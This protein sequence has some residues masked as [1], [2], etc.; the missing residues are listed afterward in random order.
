LY[1]ETHN[2]HDILYREGKNRAVH[3]LPTAFIELCKESERSCHGLRSLSS[4]YELYRRTVSVQFKKHRTSLTNMR[5][6]TI[7]ISAFLTVI[8]LDSNSQDKIDNRVIGIFSQQMFYRFTI[9]EFK[10]DMTF[11]YH[12]MSRRAHRHTSGE[13][14][15]CGDTIILN[16][17][18]KNTDFDFQ[19]KKWII[20]SR[21]QIVTNENL[22][23][24]KE[25]W[26]IFERDKRF[27]SIPKQRS[28]LAL[29]LESIKIN[30][31]SWIKDTTNYDS[32][33]KLVIHEP[34]DP[35][36]PLVILDGE[37]VEY[38]FLLNYYTMDNIDSI[39]T[40]TGEKL[41]E[42]GFHGER[43]KYGLVI[44]KTI[45]RKPKR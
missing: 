26:S 2:A 5:L 16:S 41:I 20:L 11:D 39:M 18:S 45:K 1:R 19:S 13:Y 36:E 33:L 31:L 22:N 24:R 29:K 40:M 3:S 21:K 37:P 27:D 43:S 8:F 32:E 23:D 38:D 10:R 28:D 44:V 34:S 12:I 30:E 42:A 25:N 35:K 9:V 14:S 7:I 6:R 17:Y 4:V 15:I